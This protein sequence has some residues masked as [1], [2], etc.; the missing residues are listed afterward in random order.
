MLFDRVR[1]STVADAE[2]KRIGLRYV[3]RSEELPAKTRLL[4]QLRLAEMPAAT[5]PNR[6]SRRCTITGRGR[7]IIG[8]FNV[9]RIKFREM[10]LAGQL[11]GVTK[12]SW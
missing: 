5:S 12:S 2:I 9:S 7:G 1:R 8:E 3:A 4:A 11:I 10:A 6:I